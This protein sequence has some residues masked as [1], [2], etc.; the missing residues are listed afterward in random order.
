M[1]NEIISVI[2]ALCDKLGIAVDWTAETIWPQIQCLFD[3]YAQYLLAS[4]IMWVCVWLLA[5]AFSTC[6]IVLMV[7]SVSKD[8]CNSDWLE[9]AIPAIIVLFVVDAG[10]L[11]ISLLYANTLIKVITIPDIYAAQKLL[12]MIGVV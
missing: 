1:S 5:F 4:N 3:Q 2:D 12:E 10:S 8:T 11:I 6:G 7:K 9:I